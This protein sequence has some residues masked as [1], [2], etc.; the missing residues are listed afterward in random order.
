MVRDNRKNSSNKASRTDIIKKNRAL[1]IIFAIPVIVILLIFGRT[2]AIDM[3]GSYFVRAV[4]AEQSD[5]EEL[6]EAKFIIA[7]EETVVFAPTD[8]TFVKNYTEGERVAKGAR[9]GYLLKT[10]NNDSG[11]TSKTALYS[12]E[13]GIISYK[14]DGFEEKIAAKEWTDPM[15]IGALNVEELS[16]KPDPAESQISLIADQGQGLYKIIDNLAPEFLLTSCPEISSE[17]LEIGDMIKIYTGTPQE[18]YVG[19]IKEL[20]YQNNQITLLIKLRDK[21]VNQTERSFSGK[22]VLKSYQ[23]FVST[24]D[25]IVEKD[26]KR[27]VYLL[28]R[29]TVNWREVEIA[30]RV[31]DRIAILGIGANEWVITTP[32]MVREGK[33]VSL[34]DD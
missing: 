21:L 28:Y 19:S 11:V 26:G 34:P 15:I 31:N 17:R 5:L 23:G 20:L 13:A 12:P 30:G 10:S 14:I 33:R 9:I 6:T 16:L 4:L 27:G 3:F 25:I 1:G 7:R 29:G 18:A 24:E 32:N 8:G 2:W 22:L